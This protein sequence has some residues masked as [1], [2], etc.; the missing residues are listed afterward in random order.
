VTIVHH[1]AGDHDVGAG[2]DL[3]ARGEIRQ[4]LVVLGGGGSE[5]WSAKQGGRNK[6]GKK[7][8]K[9]AR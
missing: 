2:A 8:G 6:T 9:A 4:A 3:A 5:L 7:R 1:E